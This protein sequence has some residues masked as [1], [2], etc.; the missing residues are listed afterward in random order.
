MKKYCLKKTV[1]VSDPDLWYNKDTITVKIWQLN[2]SDTIRVAFFS[3][4]D[5]MIYQDF[6]EW[7]L[8]SN[9]EWCKLWLW[10]KMPDVVSTHWMY[11]CGYRPF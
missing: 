8:D 9:W 2:N 5:K 11:M 3:I 10:D 4:D 6:S 1:R 7:N